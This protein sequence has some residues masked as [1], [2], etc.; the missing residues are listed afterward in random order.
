[1]V[2]DSGYHKILPIF[3]QSY[4]IAI[5]LPNLRIA[6]RLI[7]GTEEQLEALFKG[8]NLI[9]ILT[10]KLLSDKQVIRNET[11]WVLS[12]LAAGSNRYTSEIMNNEELVTNLLFLLESDTEEIRIEVMHLLANLTIDTDK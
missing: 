7:L 10:G 9:K 11:C 8:T 5:C 12:N 6:G 1:M 3:L 2:V 4:N